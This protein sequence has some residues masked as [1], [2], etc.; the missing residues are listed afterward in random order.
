MTAVPASFI[1][2]GGIWSGTVDLFIFSNST[3]LRSDRWD[4]VISLRWGGSALWF[5]IKS[6]SRHS[7]T[8]GAVEVHQ[9]TSL[10]LWRN[11]S[12]SKLLHLLLWPKLYLPFAKAHSAAYIK[13]SLSSK[14]RPLF[15]QLQVLDIYSINS[16]SAATVMYSYHHNHL[17]SSFRN[18]LLTSNQVHHYETRLGSQYRPHFCRTNIKQLSILYRGPTIWNSLPVTL[19]SSSPIFIFRQNLK[20]WLIDSRCIAYVFNYV[21]CT[22]CNQVSLCNIS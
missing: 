3:F 22:L 17:H 8:V 21:F 1:S 10:L 14:Y 20:N 12:L 2:F 4:T 9:L 15:S 18:L 11:I 7:V 5:P 6:V 19:T 13:S 16:F